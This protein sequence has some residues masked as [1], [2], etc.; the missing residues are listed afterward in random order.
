V[1]YGQANGN[2]S[3]TLA[4]GIGVGGPYDGVLRKMST[5]AA[6][7]AGASSAQSF[8]GAGYVETVA[9][10]TTTYRLVGFSDVD[11]DVSYTSLDYAVQLSPNGAVVVYESG[12]YRGTFGSYATGDALRVERLA[13][14]HVVYKKN[15]TTFYTS[16]GVS[17]AELRVDSALYTLGATLKDVVVSIGGGAAVPV[18][19]INDV[20]VFQGPLAGVYVHLADTNGDGRKDA[21]LQSLDGQLWVRQGNADGNFGQATAQGLGTTGLDG[22]LRKTT[23]SQRWDAGASS[24]QT[25]SGAGYVVT[26]AA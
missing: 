21:V 6:W 15:G 20:N 16:T 7:D 14:G 23:A 22:L 2:F 11:S 13:D 17:T 19:W 25:F 4:Q 26:V 18:A 8:T 12:V 24:V 9:G 5:A 3:E 10:E 1:R